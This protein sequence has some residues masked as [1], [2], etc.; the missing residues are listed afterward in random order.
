VHILDTEA[1]ENTFGPRAQRK[2]PSLLVEDV[3][4]LVVRAEASALSY[5]ADKDRDLVTEDDGVRYGD[6]RSGRHVH[7]ARRFPALR[8]R[9]TC[10]RR[11]RH[12]HVEHLGH[13][14]DGDRDEEDCDECDDVACLPLQGGS[15]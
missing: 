1:F 9:S 11:H 14:N 3:K 13:G 8:G 2:R 15:A 7:R 6:R 12:T 5:N 4:D 10:L